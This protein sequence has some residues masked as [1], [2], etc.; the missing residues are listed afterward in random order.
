[1]GSKFLNRS[2]GFAELLFNTFKFFMCLSWLMLPNGLILPPR[3]PAGDIILSS[4][5]D[6]GDVI[7]P[8]PPA[9]PFE[10]PRPDADPFEGE[11]GIKCFE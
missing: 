2:T 3:P 6:I 9:G 11:R 8:P 10:T 7:D 1:M 5:W 4:G